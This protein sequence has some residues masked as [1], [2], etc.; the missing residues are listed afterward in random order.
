[1]TQPQPIIQIKNLYKIF[2]PK[3]KSYLQAVKDGETKDELL[4]RTGHTLGL[5][6]INLDVYPGE[7]F[8]VMGLSG[9][10]KSTLI[11]HF[12][13]LIDPSEGEIIVDGSDVMKL[14]DK[15]LRDFRRHKMSM[16]FQRFGLLPHK[17]VIDNVA[18]GLQ[19]QG[20]SK[21]DRLAKAKEWIKT[22]G[23]EGYEEQYP[24]QLSGG[25]QQRVG[26][27]RALCTDAD[28]LLMDEAFSALDPLIRSEMQ[29]Q[30]IELQEKLHKTIIFIT[31]DLDEALRLGDRIAILR[32]GV[33]VQQDKPVDILLNPADDYVE[34]FVKDVNRARAL[35]VETV[36]Q[37]PISRI[38]AETLGEALT[39]MR[40]S[41]HDYGYVVTDEGY[42][43]VITQ[44]ALEQVERSDYHKEIPDEMLDDV[45]AVKSDALLEEVIP[46]TLDNDHPL[47]VVDDNGDL[48]GHLS[49]STLA[50][51]LS[52]NT[53]ENEISEEE[54]SEPKKGAA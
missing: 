52:D 8:V 46:E 18:Y 51:V 9:S 1:M 48:Q 32:D 37:P 33:V 50:D 35:T 6:D 3:D 45:P 40:R 31:H 49:K 26:L 12:N 15:D 4:A 30:L 24:S 47:P 34:A 7:I 27:A 22:V 17:S 14:S 54:T 21:T 53:S 5:Q 10:G 11:R 43:G 13:R 39:Q 38:T 28:I 19:I 23:L 29:D 36:M 44:E 2:G 16:V 25:Q 41:K 20:L 42:Q